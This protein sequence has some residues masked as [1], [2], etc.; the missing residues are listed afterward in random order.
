MITEKQKLSTHPQQDVCC[1]IGQPIAGNPTQ[2]MLEKAFEAARLDWRFLT[3]EVPAVDLEGALRGARIFG[4]NGIMLAPPHRNSVIPYLQEVGE[5]ARISGQVNCI[6]QTD[7][8]LFGYNTEGRALRQLLEQT[9]AVKGLRVT[10][11]GSGRIAR[12]IA[13]ELALVG[14]GEI[15]FL[16]RNPEKV[17]ELTKTLVTQ[18]PLTSCHADQLAGDS[19]FAIDD[20][21]QVLI[22]AT[23]VG[24]NQPNERLPLDLDD[25]EKHTIVADAVFNPPNTWL[26]KEAQARGCRTVDGLTLL[27][28]QAALAFE[29]WTGAAADRQAMR[30][31][32]EE[33]LV[34]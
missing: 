20:T 13:A 14:A 2:Y 6:K 17:E 9:G 4:F 12:A 18:T 22:N 32:V 16:C 27:L 19:L 25:L 15:R 11:V 33:F 31:A 30:E 24:P 23:P 26:M 21:F 34:L 8:R 7:G 5:A 28:E 29:I 3:F 10:I 1:L